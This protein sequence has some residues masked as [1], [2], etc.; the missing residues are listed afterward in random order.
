L[1]YKVLNKNLFILFFQRIPTLPLLLK[2]E[3]KP[4]PSSPFK[5]EGGRGMGL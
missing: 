3:E 5:G 4:L 2:R 1:S